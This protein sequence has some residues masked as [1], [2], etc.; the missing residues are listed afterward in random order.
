MSSDSYYWSALSLSG[1]IGLI[2]YL[3]N[4]RKIL[5]YW[6]NVLDNP[7]IREPRWSPMMLTIGFAAFIAMVFV[8]PFFSVIG[9]LR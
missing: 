6:K 8:L 5:I 2:V 4:W 7:F 1:F 9:I 3:A